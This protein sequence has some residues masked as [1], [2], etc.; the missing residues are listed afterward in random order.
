MTL[1]EFMLKTSINVKDNQSQIGNNLNA[2]LSR[3]G[4]K[5]NFD[6]D[7]NEVTDMELYE[8]GRV[9]LLTEGA[10]GPYFPYQILEKMKELIENNK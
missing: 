7:I 2:E 5:I 8:I 4:I 10:P 9:L 3:F 6:K 1:H